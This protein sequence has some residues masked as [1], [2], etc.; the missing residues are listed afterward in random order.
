MIHEDEEILHLT[1]RMV[2]SITNEKTEFYLQ[3]L[4]HHKNMYDKN[5][6]VLLLLIMQILFV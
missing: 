4:K 2:I 6:T 1:L 5:Y 3:E